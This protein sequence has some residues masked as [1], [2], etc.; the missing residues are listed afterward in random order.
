MKIT[1][2]FVALITPL[3]HDKIDVE[4]LQGLVQ[5]HSQQG[6]DGLVVLGSTGISSLLEVHER[7]EVLQTVV[8]TNAALKKKMKIIAGCGPFSTRDVQK[9]AKMAADSGVD[10]L[11][12]SA[13]CYVKPT[14]EGLFKHFVNVSETVSL[15]FV[16]Y[17]NPGRAC[18]NLQLGT[19]IRMCDT[20]PQIVAIKD[21]TSDLSRVSFLQSN[22]KGRVTLLAGDDAVNLGFLAQGGDGTISVTAN[23]FPGAMKAFV[24]AWQEGNIQ[25][26][27]RI[28]QVLGPVHEQMFCEPNPCPAVFALAQAGKV[29]NEVRLPLLPVEQ[30]SASA[31]AI[32]EAVQEATQNI[33][34][35][36]RYRYV[37]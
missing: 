35:P 3:H 6:T 4:A 31:Q 23:V 36:T 15:P 5:W 14:Q 19:L 7:K 30:E 29:H 24:K 12:L 8:R 16:I 11:M 21:S 17:N 10:A 1:G 34:G 20:M 27:S 18:I 28:H 37:G 22:L 33:A 9:E 13:P 26:A 32:E 25:E 2:S